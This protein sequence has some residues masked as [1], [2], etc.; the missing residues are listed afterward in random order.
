MV[1]N[2]HSRPEQPMLH[3]LARAWLA[4]APPSA[5]FF[6]LLANAAA[7]GFPGAKDELLKVLERTD[8][9]KH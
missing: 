1:G 5:E 7:A 9:S 3:E 8:G 4:G 6:S 2:G